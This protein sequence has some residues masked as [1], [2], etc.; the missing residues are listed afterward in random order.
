MECS[1]SGR[2]G[3]IFVCFSRDLRSAFRH[4]AAAAATVASSRN[5]PSLGSKL[6]WLSRCAWL[7]S[8]KLFFFF[9]FLRHRCR[10][11]LSQRTPNFVSVAHG[12]QRLS[13]LP[14]YSFVSWRRA[15]HSADNL[16]S[17]LFPGRLQ[18]HRFLFLKNNNCHFCCFFQCRS[19]VGFV[20]WFEARFANVAVFSCGRI[21]RSCN[22]LGQLFLSISRTSY[23]V[24]LK[25][26]VHS[27][28]EARSDFNL[29]FALLFSSLSYFVFKS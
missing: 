28:F 22:I 17:V 10:F 3:R 6:Q 5:F 23:L 15:E 2:L 7:Y 16:E 18:L 26:E 19:R 20:A 1:V 9:F 29:V 8:R 12:F 14:V 27:I 13:L 25:V 11:I 24:Q 4:A 21:L